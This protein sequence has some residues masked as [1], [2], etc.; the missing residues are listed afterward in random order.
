MQGKKES[1]DRERERQRRND[2]NSTILTV[3]G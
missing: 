3:M 2:G 1:D